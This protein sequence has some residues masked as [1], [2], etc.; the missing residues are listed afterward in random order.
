ME[1]RENMNEEK[2]LISAEN[3]FHDICTLT[4]N[5]NIEIDIIQE[6][7]LKKIM[8]DEDSNSIQF[9]E[10]S[11]NTQGDLTKLNV[12]LKVGDKNCTSKKNEFRYLDIH[13]IIDF[14]KKKLGYSIDN[15][16][17]HKCYHYRITIMLDHITQGGLTFKDSILYIY[18][19]INDKNSMICYCFQDAKI[20]DKILNGNG[21]NN[22]N[23]RNRDDIKQS[24][25]F[26]TS[27]KFEKN[28]NWYEQKDNLFLHKNKY[29]EQL[30]R[31]PISYSFE[32]NIIFSNGLND[33]SDENKLH[34]SSHLKHAKRD[35]SRCIEPYVAGD[36]LSSNKEHGGEELKEIKKE[37]NILNGEAK[38]SFSGEVGIVKGTKNGTKKEKKK[39]AKKGD[40][41]ETETGTEKGREKANVF[42]QR[43]LSENGDTGAEVDVVGA[44]KQENGVNTVF[45]MKD[46]E[47]ISHFLQDDFMNK[48]GKGGN[49]LIIGSRGG[50][51]IREDENRKKKFMKIMDENIP[52]TVILSD[53]GNDICKELINKYSRYYRDFVEERVLGCGGFGYVMKVKNKR[54]NISYALKKITLCSTKK[55]AYSYPNSSSD[56]M[57]ENN[58]YIMEEAI[59]I[60][61][62]QHENIVR[63]YDAWVENNID[64]YL[65][66]EIENNYEHISKKKRNY[67]HYMEEIINMRHYYE[68]KKGID[69]NEKYLYIL[70][71]YCPGKTLRE[72]IDCGIIYK[73]EKLIWELIKQIL[74]GLHY[75]H[76]MKVMHRDIKP[77]NIFLQISDN[78]L[79]AKIGDFGLTTRI[80]NN[81]NNINP[82]AGTVNYISPEQLNGEYVDQKSDIFSLGVVFFEMFHEPFS[83]LMERSIVLSNLLKGIYP[84]YIKSDQKNFQ[85]LSK[86][87]AINP[88]ERSCAYSLL[89][90]NF[91]FSF[92]KDFTEIYNLVE[93]KGNC[94]EVH[95]IISTLFDKTYNT[96]EED[97]VK[98]ED[99][100]SFQSAKMFIEESDMKKCIKKKIIKSLKKRGAV[101]LITPIIL[102][103]RYYINPEHSYVGE[104]NCSYNLNKK[105]DI[106]TS[107][108]YINTNKNDVESLV[109][110]LDIYGNSITLRPSF[111]FAFAE[112]IYENIGCY[113]KYNESTFFLKFYANGY[114]YK[115]P[116]IKNKPSKKVIHTAIYPEE[117]EKI[118]YC[119]LISSKNLYGQEELN[120]LSI[121][122]NADIFVSVYT[123]YNHISCFNKL[124]FIWSYIDLLPLILNECLDI[125][126]DISE[127]MSIQLKKNSTLLANKSSIM[128]IL[129]KFKINN[130]NLPKICDFIYTL[131]QLKCENGKVEEYLSALDTFISDFLSKKAGDH[132]PSNITS[133]TIH[134]D[135]TSVNYA[136]S[137]NITGGA[138]IS[139]NPSGNV[140]TSDSASSSAT[141]TCHA[142]NIGN[143]GRN[144][145]PI[146]STNHAASSPLRANDTSAKKVHIILNEK[147][148]TK[149]VKNVRS[150]SL[151]DIVKKINSFIGTS[152]MI[153]NTC[154]DLFLNYEESLFSN[155]IIFYVIAEGKNRDI[156]ACGGKFDKVLQNMKN[157]ADRGGARGSIDSSNGGAMA[158][159]MRENICNGMSNDMSNDMNENIFNDG[160]N[161]ICSAVDFD[162]WNVLNCDIK[163]D[164]TDFK[165]LN[166]KA[167][168]VEIFVEKIFLKVIESNEKTPINV[169]ST[170]ASDK[171]QIFKN[172]LLSS[173]HQNNFSCSTNLIQFPASNCSFSYSSPKVLIQVYKMAVLLIAYDL[174][175]KLLDKNIPSY[176][177]FSINNANTKKKIKNFKPHKIRFIISIKSF[178]NDASIDIHNPVNINNVTYKVFNSKN[179]DCNFMQQEELINYLI[180]NV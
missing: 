6:G 52:L 142:S 81:N 141:C 88:K 114:T 20:V 95:T 176:I 174:S 155:E 59:M 93:N 56:I 33:E 106:K 2:V 32:Q 169:P 117:I 147:T 1:K 154:F 70:M 178:G 27:D 131:F 62:L 31:A 61:K 134:G 34:K 172:F 138:S 163:D 35:S 23:T 171:T 175:K 83:T 45:S 144:Y 103:N 92:E 57:N 164:C 91:L 79:T 146:S 17:I 25:T 122:S 82:S 28:M 126:A 39:E 87:L 113:N 124:L 170:A 120:Y 105:K 40:K 19:G 129:Q 127:E 177:Y 158:N 29:I 84:E 30:K 41:K 36:L 24:M 21:S 14:N 159:H 60:A 140:G 66:N 149:A 107:N 132:L 110:L 85:F 180:K 5:K 90:E 157:G 58:R 7:L 116:I 78:V 4:L 53:K 156:I 65:H 130:N 18:N 168:G 42:S 98:K 108:I 69:I 63:Y 123:L 115:Y 135:K 48:R 152:T 76:D 150:H 49:A 77:S 153:E 111:F 162:T 75:I 160:S 97:V 50:K 166:M 145:S 37:Y 179:E 12:H 15:S 80:D 99:M 165:L 121:F 3:I 72:A 119:I 71:E 94:E 67:A 139:A 43:E 46:M 148:N 10:E 13:I 125:P 55:K 136:I 151:I 118:F 8:D 89:H 51:Y 167:Y 109:Y 112:Y 11:S 64:Y 128:P 38:K 133:C 143:V 173:D 47:E 104:S 26:S 101:F 68:E 54:F 16:N 96:K 137:D 73:N 9:V 100:V 44:V 22:L 161:N 74:K 86:L 102:R